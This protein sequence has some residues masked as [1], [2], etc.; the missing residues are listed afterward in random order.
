MDT[1]LLDAFARQR[2]VA[3]VDDVDSEGPRRLE[4]REHH[5]IV[6]AVEYCTAVR[7]SSS[8]RGTT[9]KYEQMFSAIGSALSEL[10]GE[11][12]ITVRK[13]SPSEVEAAAIASN[14]REMQSRPTDGFS[15]TS[16]FYSRGAR[17]VQVRPMSA[18]AR[19]GHANSEPETPRLGSFEVL[20]ELVNRQSGQRYGPIQIHSKL[21]TRRWPLFDK[22]RQRLDVHLQEFL[23][24]DSGD[25]EYYQACFPIP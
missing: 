25:F 20:F 22:L 1:S 13:A 2:G 4:A 9:E 10:S 16:T 24:K 12:E 21:L 6:I 3:C 19:L 18:H 15:K 23:A 14:R 8:L 17:E 7:P 11:G 5:E